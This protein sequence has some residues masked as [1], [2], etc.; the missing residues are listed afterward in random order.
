MTAPPQM[1]GNA[2]PVMTMVDPMAGVN[3]MLRAIQSC[4]SKAAG[5]QSAA[6][7]KDFAA[8]ALSFAQAI[9]VLDPSL[10]QGGTPLQHDL[11]MEAQRGQTQ[12][13]VAQ[14]QGQTQLAAEKIRG[15]HALRAA[16]ETAAAPT[17]KKQITINRADGRMTGITQEG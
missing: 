1:N 5:A 13:N 4:G 9:I 2:P 17:P 14:I 7:A 16:K 12:E 6:E 10:S 11:A 15:E 8:A 3:E